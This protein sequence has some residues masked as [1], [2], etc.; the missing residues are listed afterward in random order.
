MMKRAICESDAESSGTVRSSSAQPTCLPESRPWAARGGVD[1]RPSKVKPPER[2]IDAADWQRQ[3]NLRLRAEFI[4][5]AEENWHKRTGHPGRI[6]SVHGR[7][8][9]GSMPTTSVVPACTIEAK[10]R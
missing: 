1:R 4:A 9:C 2:A 6:G 7:S 3:M 5:W 8:L 10:P